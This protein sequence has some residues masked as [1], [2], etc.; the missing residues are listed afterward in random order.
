MRFRKPID[1]QN[2]PERA[3]GLPDFATAVNAIKSSVGTLFTGGDPSKLKLNKFRKGARFCLFVGDEG[4]I[5][6]YMKSNVVLS[7]QFVPDTSEQ[8]LDELRRSLEVDTQ[9]PVSLIIDNLDQTYVQ[10]SLPPVSAISVKKLMKRRLERDFGANDIKG[11]VLLGREKTG[12]KDWNFLMVS[13]EKNMQI[14]LWLNFVYNLPNRFVGIYLASIE[15]ENILRKLEHAMGA[16]QG[17]AASKWKFFVSHNKVGGFRQV[18]LR[19]GRIVFTRMAQPIGESTPEVIAGNIEQEMQSTIEYMKRLSFDPKSGLDIYIIAGSAIKPVIDKSKFAIKNFFILTP[20][21]AAGYLGI[22]GATQPTDQF[23]DVILA[24]SISSSVKHVLTFNTPESTKF[25]KLYTIFHAQRAVAALVLLGM[26]LYLGAELMDIYSLYRTADEI[27]DN[28]TRFK[29]KLD[30]VH[31]QIDRDHIDIYRTLDT[32]D[33]YQALEQHR[34]SPLVFIEKI[35]T[36]IKPPIIV[37]SIDWAIDDK[38][39]V[40]TPS[41]PKINVVFVLEFPDVKTPEAW[42]AVSKKFLADIKA[43]FKGY[44]ASFTKV[45][46]GLSEA[47]KIDMTFDA[48]AAKTPAPDTN[49]EVQLTIREL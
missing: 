25:N 18:I 4:A 3:G 32:I 22:E 37:K 13:I 36:V 19:D 11:A 16:P 48:P 34:V 12:R 23:G 38:V 6:V 49:R 17:A 44:D 24:A 30:V 29:S 47:E 46:A 5:L 33:L 26:T 42:R 43:A 15:T 45:P 35:E 9:A 1:N 20:Y 2:K 7:R 14:S 31:A 10:Q 41:S 27:A 28:H 21:E 40:D 8:N 39:N